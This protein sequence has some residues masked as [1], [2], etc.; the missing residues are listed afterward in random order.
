MMITTKNAQIITNKNFTKNILYTSVYR[1]THRWLAIKKKY[2]I[3]QNDYTHSV[4]YP[5]LQEKPFTV[6]L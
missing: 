1:K 4:I 5:T 2:L 3:H 6:H